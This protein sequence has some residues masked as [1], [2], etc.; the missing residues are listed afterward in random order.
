LQTPVDVNA[1]VRGVA[2]LM[3]FDA[4]SAKA[5]IRF[6]LLEPLPPVIADRIQ[7]EQVMVNLMRNAFEAMR[8]AAPS[9]R[10]LTVRT[11]MGNGDR[12]LVSVCD[13]GAGIAPETMPRLFDRFFTTKPDGMGMGLPISQS[14]I[15]SHGGHLW[16]EANAGRGAT[17]CF[18]LPIDRGDESHGQ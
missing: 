5:E 12:M 10:V 11:A 4:W 18:T 14:I 9:H 3:Q 13:T 16:A 2:E 15:E 7:L 17:F 6:K 8:N 1:M